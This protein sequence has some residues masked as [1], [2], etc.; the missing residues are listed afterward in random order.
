MKRTEEKTFP[1]PNY[2]HE[3]EGNIS[4]EGCFGMC[5]IEQHRLTLLNPL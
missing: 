2:C 1:L 4:H 5:D 3:K